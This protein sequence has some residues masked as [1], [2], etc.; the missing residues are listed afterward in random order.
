MLTSDNSVFT[1]SHDCEIDNEDDAVRVDY[2]FQYDFRYSGVHL[3]GSCN[4]LVALLYDDNNNR[5]KEI[6]LIWNP[7][8]R[9]IKKLPKSP[10]QIVFIGFIIGDIHAFGY[11]DKIDDYKLAKVVNI[12]WGCVVDVYTFGT[13]EWKPIEQIIPYHLPFGS[14][15][16]VLVHGNL[17]WLGETCAEDVTRVIVSFNFSDE[18]FEA[19]QLPKGYP[20]LCGVVRRVPL[21]TF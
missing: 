20:F 17:H 9:E 13:I 18:R 3:W 7:V 12:R 21:Y 19:L 4:G 6:I 15:P 1:I 16:G 14:V 10:A 5:N 8:T 2:P 11:D